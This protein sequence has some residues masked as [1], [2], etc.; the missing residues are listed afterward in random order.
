[1]SRLPPFQAFQAARLLPLALLA[2]ILCWVL[3]APARA[4]SSNG[5]DDMVVFGGHQEVKE[6]QEVDGDLVVLG[7][8]AD[9][10]GTIHGDAVAI[11]GAIHVWP[12]GSVE[13]S[14]VSL[15]GTINNESTITPHTPRHRRYA[16][17]P[18]VAPD[19]V[20]PPEVVDQPSA[21]N[22]WG[23]FFALDA[24]LVLLAFLL[25]PVKTREAMEYLLENPLVAGVAG[26]FSPIILALLVTALAITVIGIPL[27]PLVLIMTVIGYLIGKAALAAFLGNRLFEVARVESPKPIVSMLVGL[28][29][30][31]VISMFGWAGIVI[32]FCIA[33]IALGTA[34]YGFVRVVNKR[35]RLTSFIPPAAPPAQEFAPPVGPA[36]TGPPAV[37]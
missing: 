13:G 6:G 5:S 17:V 25:F 22:G 15:G 20:T 10:Y 12:Q 18:P 31:T 21:L 4:F 30:L 19:T 11:G 29:I 35:R 8:S 7:G 28:A 33:A 14:F 26:F 32:Y 1:M 16:P 2:A 36:P 23:T 27:I 3:P 9:V 37:P 24:L 34:L